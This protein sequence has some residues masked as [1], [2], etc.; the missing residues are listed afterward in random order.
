MGR[1]T[2]FKHAMSNTER[3]RRF[4]AGKAKPVKP[5][6]APGRPDAD[7]RARF[8][9]MQAELAAAKAAARAGTTAG[10]RSMQR[11][12]AQATSG[13]ERLLEEGLG[14]AKRQLVHLRREIEELS[15]LPTDL[16]KRYRA[17]CKRFRAKEKASNRNLVKALQQQARN[18]RRAWGIDRVTFNKIAKALHPD[19]RT[20][21]S[22]MNEAHGLFTE[23]KKQAERRAS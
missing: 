8:A 17:F 11:T 4:R 19:H 10:G 18:E 5:R 20:T 21:P 3:S 9:A 16:T 2:I 22:E 7:L 12:A 1:P 15:K 13:R 14:H 6:P 23:W